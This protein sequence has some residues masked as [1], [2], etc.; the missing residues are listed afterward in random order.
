[1][2]S[3]GINNIDFHFGLGWGSFNGSNQK[4]KNPLSYFHDSLVQEAVAGEGGQFQL[5]RY[6]SGKN[7]SPFNNYFL[8]S[9]Q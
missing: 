6:F 7:V 4:I 8:C 5:S 1:M 3:Y 2:A 9:K